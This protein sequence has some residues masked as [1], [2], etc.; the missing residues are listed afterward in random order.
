MASQSIR[1][2]AELIK[3]KCCIR[4]TQNSQTNR[5]YYDFRYEN[6]IPRF[7]KTPLTEPQSNQSL[8]SESPVFCESSQSGQQQVD[9]PSTGLS[10][11][12]SPR[13]PGGEAVEASPNDNRG[14]RS[15]LASGE[16]SRRWLGAAQSQKR[17]PW[18][19]AASAPGSAVGWGVW[20]VLLRRRRSLVSAIV[21]PPRTAMHSR[22]ATQSPSVCLQSWKGRGRR[23]QAHLKKK[24]LR[25]LE[26][27]A[28]S[29]RICSGS[30]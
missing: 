16:E 17:Y 24:K 20:K 13:C 7:A 4:L 26:N 29:K 18:V 10:K 8:S 22:P 21:Q 12:G 11:R 3:C 19:E 23:C 25:T 1:L 9:C 30:P 15:P 6:V 5:R 28:F 2:S 27:P 14:R